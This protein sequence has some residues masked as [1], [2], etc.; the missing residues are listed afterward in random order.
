[1]P[2]PSLRY[3]LF[4]MFT[5]QMITEAHAKMKSGAD[6]PA[7]VAE[8][9][10]MGI[11]RYDFMA[12]T[13]MNVYYGNDQRVEVAPK[14]ASLPVADVASPAKLRHTIEIH[15]QGQTDFMTF[16]LQATASGVQKW[17]SDLEEM[18]VIYMDKGGNEIL[19]EPIPTGEY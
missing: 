8:L 13:G 11:I 2:F 18:A 17:V 1:M 14:Y 5:E 4:N 12:D 3:K 7:Y 9:K 15:Q 19:R 10:A 6:Y 16:C